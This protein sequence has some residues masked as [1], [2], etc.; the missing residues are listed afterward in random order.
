MS[1]IPRTVDEITPEWLTK[2]LRDSGAVREACIE[3]IEVSNVGDSA[4]VAGLVSRFE[5]S[6]NVAEP[7]APTT[8][9]TK[10]AVADDEKRALGARMNHIEV[11]FYRQLAASSGLRAPR[12]YYS[13]GEEESGYIVH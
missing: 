3:S 11:Q 2:V 4:G 1:D 12:S 8:I 5:L 13:D 9:I 10:Q 6:Y 7:D